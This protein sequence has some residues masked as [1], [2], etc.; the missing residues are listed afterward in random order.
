M[1]EAKVM[2]SLA[3]RLLSF[4]STNPERDANYDISVTLRKHSS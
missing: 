4:V 3:D 2:G 1:S